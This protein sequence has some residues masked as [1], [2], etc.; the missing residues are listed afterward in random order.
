MPMPAS[1]KPTRGRRAAAVEAGGIDLHRHAAVLGDPRQSSVRPSGRPVPAAPDRDRR[2]ARACRGRAGGHGCRRVAAAGRRRTAVPACGALAPSGGGCG[3]PRR[4]LCAT[5]R[6]RDGGPSTAT[7]RRRPPASTSTSARTPPAPRQSAAS[8]SAN[9]APAP[10]RRRG[11]P[12][13]AQRSVGG[14]A[15]FCAAIAFA[16]TTACCNWKSVSSGLAGSNFGKPSGGLSGISLAIGGRSV[17]GGGA[18]LPACRPGSSA[19]G[20]GRPRAPA[21]NAAARS[22]V[23]ATF[24]SGVMPSPWIERPDGV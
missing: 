22:R 3:S 15:C 16:S 20:S 10:P 24:T 8:G 11:A 17:R 9:A 23:S 5:A 4:R 1:S 13:A 18:C 7:C 6:C 21:R 14:D 2:S 19:R 12:G